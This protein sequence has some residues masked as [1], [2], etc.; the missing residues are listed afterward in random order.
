MGNT[1][2]CC[3]T[4]SLGGNGIAE[5]PAATSLEDLDSGANP[6]FVLREGHSRFMWGTYVEA[7]KD[8]AGSEDA[9]GIASYHPSKAR[10][11]AA[12]K[13][14]GNYSMLIADVTNPHK[15]KTYDGSKP[16]TQVELKRI[17]VSMRPYVDWMLRELARRL[18]GSRRC[19]VL[20]EKPVG[21]DP[22]RAKVWRAVVVYLE[23]RVQSTTYQKPGREPDMSQPAAGAFLAVLQELAYEADMPHQ[24]WKKLEDT[25]KRTK[26]AADIGADGIAATHDQQA[27]DEAAQKLIGNHKA[28]IADLTNPS[29]TMNIYGY[30]LTQ[31]HNER[32]PFESKAHVDQMLR[33]VARRL[34]GQR[35]GLKQLEE[36]PNLSNA[37]QIKAYAGTKAYLQGRLQSKPGQKPGRQPDMSEPAAAAFLAVVEEVATE[38]EANRAG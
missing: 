33:E 21:R 11:E 27:R 32:V 2:Q 13:L 37:E 23:G 14:I 8:P 6:P 30:P 4:S 36:R 31:I 20:Q 38:A 10:E 12:K 18:L 15:D 9:E 19:C 17:D 22:E 25:W 16:L 35:D 7:L 29:K 28:V 26:T 5:F 1:T 24:N 3:K 34:L